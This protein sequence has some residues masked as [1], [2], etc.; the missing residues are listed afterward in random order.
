[1]QNYRHQPCDCNASSLHVWV[2]LCYI[3]LQIIQCQKLH[4]K[5]KIIA[6]GHRWN[7]DSIFLLWYQ[8]V[9]SQHNTSAYIVKFPVLALQKFPLRRFIQEIFFLSSGI[10]ISL[11]CFAGVDGKY[12]KICIMEL[13]QEN[14]LFF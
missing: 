9:V 1:M 11:K 13:Q 8:S 4:N 5:N 7:Q 6:L 3:A 2:W 14:L 12:P 10:H